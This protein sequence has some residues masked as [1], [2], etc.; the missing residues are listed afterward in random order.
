MAEVVRHLPSQHKICRFKHQY[1]IYIYIY[2]Y[3]FMRLP[4]ARHMPII[5]VTWLAT[6]EAEIRR[7][8]V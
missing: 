2:I 5:L 6:W 7:I 4:E 8:K 1:Y 3:L